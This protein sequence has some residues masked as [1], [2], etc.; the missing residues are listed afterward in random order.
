MHLISIRFRYVKKAE[1]EGSHGRGSGIGYNR[2]GGY[3]S[4]DRP[5]GYGSNDRFRQGGNFGGPSRRNDGFADQQLQR[6]DWDKEQLAP[7]QKNFFKPAQ[8]VIDRSPDEI[9]A[10]HE[11]HDI[12]VRGQKAPTTIFDFKEVG[13]PSYITDQLELKGFQEPTVIQSQSWPIAMAGRDMVGIAQTGSGNF[14]FIN[15]V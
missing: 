10:F 13:F 6:I 7:L 15:I 4:N 9:K 8:S 3:G 14:A 12:S 5:G 1:D 11:K 2:S